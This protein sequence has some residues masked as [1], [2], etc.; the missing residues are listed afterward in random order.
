MTIPAFARMPLLVA[1][2]L[3]LSLPKEGGAWFGLV[4]VVFIVWAL[5]NL[6]RLI[7]KPVERRVR[8]ARFAV[9]LAVVA[10]AGATQ[11]HWSTASRE[12]AD[13]TAAA[14]LEYKMRTGSYPATLAEAG[15]DEQSLRAEWQVGYRLRDGIPELDYPASIMPLAIYEY[16]FAARRWKTNAY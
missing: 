12:H 2:V 6:V 15:L 8:V 1:I 13:A 9:W 3:F 11:A 16:D 14:L 10:L 7:L 5:Y 4:L